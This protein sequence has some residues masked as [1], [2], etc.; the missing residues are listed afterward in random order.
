MEA[1]DEIA[2]YA[3]SDVVCYLAEH[4][5]PLVERQARE[6][7]PWRDWAARELGV[8]PRTIFRYLERD[9]G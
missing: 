8:D 3:G 2:A 1:S 9:E 5:T 7:T 6:W 4:P